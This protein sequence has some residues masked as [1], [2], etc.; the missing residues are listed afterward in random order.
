MYVFNYNEN[1]FRLQKKI[2]F[3]QKKS[4]LPHVSPESLIMST[5]INDIK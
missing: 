2:K 1:D 3:F 4:L 5:N